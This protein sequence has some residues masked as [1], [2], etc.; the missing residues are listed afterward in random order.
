[1]DIA[2]YTNSLNSFSMEKFRSHRIFCD[3][4]L[5]FQPGQRGVISNG[6][7]WVEMFWIF[8]LCIVSFLARNLYCDYLYLVWFHLSLLLQ[9]FL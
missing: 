7:V 3:R 4:I 6:K 9:F 1:M 8:W 2:A 5:D